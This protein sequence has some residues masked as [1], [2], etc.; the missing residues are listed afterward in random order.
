MG[1][2]PRV[3]TNKLIKGFNVKA[4]CADGYMGTAKVAACNVSHT[5]YHLSGCRPQKCVEPPKEEMENYEL[6]VWL[7][8]KTVA[9][10]SCVSFFLEVG[11]IHFG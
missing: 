9:W 2:A 8:R 7:G 3:E 5:P 11:L 10:S 1:R 6:T 4:T